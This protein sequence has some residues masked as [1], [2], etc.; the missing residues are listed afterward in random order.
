[1]ADVNLGNVSQANDSERERIERNA[2]DFSC[3]GPVRVF[4]ASSVFWLLVGSAFAL[5]ASLKMHLP[6]W[7][8]Q[9]AWLT[10]GRVRPAHL[11][12]VSYG[13]ASMAGISVA[14]WMMAR[15]C[16]VELRY[17]KL[18]IFAAIIWNTGVLLGT[19]GILIGH[20]TSVEWLEFPRYVPPFLAI[21]LLMVSAVIYSTFR[22]R[23]SAHVYVTQWYLMGAFFWLPLLYIT[24]VT[25]ILYGP[26]P[27]LVKL[28]TRGVV[29]SSV[30][31]WYAHNVLGLWLTPI[32]VGAAYYL[33]PKVIGRPIHSY[34]LSIIGFWSLA[35]FYSWAGMHHL[36][37]G[38][39][40]A[41]MISASIAGSMMMII[42]V[43]AVALNHHMTMKN[44]FSELRFSPTLRFVVFG[45]LSYTAVSF[46]G[47]I[48]SL[49]KFSEVAHF[50][51]YTIGH[52]H[53]GLYGFF[54][55]TMFGAAYYMLPRITGV[56]WA[57]PNLIRIH[58]WSSATGIVIYFCAL[59]VGGWFQ[60]IAML[61]PDIK[62]IQIVGDTIPYLISRSI[63][64]SLMTLGHIVF[65]ILVV[66]NLMGRGR[67]F[68]GVTR[69]HQPSKHVASRAEVVM[70]GEG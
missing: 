35:L 54:T 50:T 20:S 7:L 63:G 41:W 18:L 19:I 53:L 45:A 59:S 62:F 13:W 48:E 32:G 31:W 52:A 26:V 1:M 68:A 34:Y 36:I 21:A 12:A 49:R 65:A 25:L 6:E 5:I 66:L 70:V 22:R 4:F 24:A 28:T 9:S 33:I 69:F 43:G 27:G 38:P 40:P 30:N 44:H 55:M 64:G 42:P 47:S 39:I 17:Q 14:L 23:Q 56:E 3:R 58:F 67:P 16:R 57:S 37:G 11:N 10:F 61:N 29:Q 60:G 51:H 15:L 8:G 46:Q 2:I